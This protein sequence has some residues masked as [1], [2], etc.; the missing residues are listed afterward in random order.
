MKSKVKSTG[1]EV[2]GMDGVK[3]PLLVRINKSIDD[4]KDAIVVTCVIILVAIIL[5]IFG[6]GFYWA[7][8]ADNVS[9]PTISSGIVVGK[10]DY[11]YRGKQYYALEYE[12]VNEDGQRETRK[13]YVTAITYSEYNIGDTFNRENHTFTHDQ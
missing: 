11:V 2:S 12:G 9:Q 6:A 1:F 4:H 5:T 3:D 10:E 13:D 8:V 7:I